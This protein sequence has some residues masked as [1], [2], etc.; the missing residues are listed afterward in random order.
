MQFFFP[1]ALLLTFSSLSSSLLWWTGIIWYADLMGSQWIP[2]SENGRMDECGIMMAYV[3]LFHMHD[4]LICGYSDRSHIFFW[5]THT[6]TLLTTLLFYNS[7]M[8]TWQTT[9][10]PRDSLFILLFTLSWCCR[11][12]HHHSISRWSLATLAVYKQPTSQ[13]SQLKLKST[14]DG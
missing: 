3:R 13:Q 7:I 10:I 4:Q 12:H 11:H 14:T 6:H 5:S 2:L 8:M 9:I 1:L